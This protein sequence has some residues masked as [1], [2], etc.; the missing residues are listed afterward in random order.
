MN[1]AT[2]HLVKI[3]G[4]KSISEPQ[5]LIKPTPFGKNCQLTLSGSCKVRRLRQVKS[6]LSRNG[7]LANFQ[8]YPLLDG[9]LLRLAI[10]QFATCNPVRNIPLMFK[11][12]AKLLNQ[13]EI[14]IPGKRSATRN[15]VLSDNS[16]FRLS[17]E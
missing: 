17:P 16:G 14:V 8:V 5:F 2:M 3:Q 11:P 9:D 10:P 4:M 15:S 7:Q 12:P 13:E 6:R 1:R